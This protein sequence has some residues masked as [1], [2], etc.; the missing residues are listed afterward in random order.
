MKV[1]CTRLNK[2]ISTLKTESSSKLRVT[3]LPKVC[4]YAVFSSQI[5]LRRS[6]LWKYRAFCYQK[7]KRIF[8]C[9]ARK[10]HHSVRRFCTELW[11]LKRY[12]VLISCVEFHTKRTI[13][14]EGKSTNLFTPLSTTV[15][16]RY[17]WN[18]HIR[19][20]VNTLNAELNPICYLLALL[21][22]HFLHFSRIRVNM[23][24]GLVTD[25]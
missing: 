12:Y 9:A 14:M 6:L 13:N 3:I 16:A 25:N 18:S 17:S 7:P 20:H 5:S 10:V 4:T 24:N 23:K 15:A 2:I 1:Q 11:N 22:R 19:L 21:S 8:I